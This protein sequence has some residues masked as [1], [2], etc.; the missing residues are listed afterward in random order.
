MI[1]RFIGV[2]GACMALCVCAGAA[3]QTTPDAKQEAREKFNAG[4]EAINLGDVKGAFKLFGQSLALKRAPGTLL[5]LADCEQRLGLFASAS[6][7]YKEVTALVP[8]TDE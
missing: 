4:R 7:H 2:L 3:A 6:A 1:A 8:D 5:N